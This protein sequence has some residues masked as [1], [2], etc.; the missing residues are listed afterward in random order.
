MRSSGRISA[1]DDKQQRILV[2]PEIYST[3]DVNK[4]QQSSKQKVDNYQLSVT[5]LAFCM[6]LEETAGLNAAA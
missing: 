1:D 6:E 3:P 2:D 4:M 5:K